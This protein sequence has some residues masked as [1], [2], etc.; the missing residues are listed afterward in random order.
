MLVVAV[1]SGIQVD[2]ENT[3]LTPDVLVTTTMV[4]GETDV[5]VSVHVGFDAMLVCV[6]N[7]G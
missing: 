4:V 2:V 3:V 6:S 5:S 1:L 7:D